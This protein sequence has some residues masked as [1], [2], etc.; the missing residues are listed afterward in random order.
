[1]EK[2]KQVKRRQKKIS[3]LWFSLTQY[4]LALS[5]CIQ[6]M[7]TLALTGAEKPVTKLFIGEKEKSTKREW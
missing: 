4:T 1:M 5:R 6:N 7:K 3:A 2:R